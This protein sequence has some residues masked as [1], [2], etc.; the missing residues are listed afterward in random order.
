[1]AAKKTKVTSD[2]HFWNCCDGKGFAWLLIIIGA[3]WLAKDMG[4]IPGSFSF[5]PIAFLAWGIYLLVKDRR[6]C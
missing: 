4:F 5:W 6:S 1:M 3:F 2:K